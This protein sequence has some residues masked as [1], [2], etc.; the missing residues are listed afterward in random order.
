MRKHLIILLVI[1]SCLHGFTQD[2]LTIQVG[3]CQTIELNAHKDATCPDGYH[4]D[5]DRDTLKITGTLGANC[6]GTHLALI[7]KINDTIFIST[8]DTGQLCLCT[9]Y[10]CF[11]LKLPASVNDT[12]VSIHG[13]IYNTNV[14][15]DAFTEMQN[16]IDIMPNPATDNISISATTD[17]VQISQIALYSVSGAFVKSF[18]A[19][20]VKET[21]IS[22]SELKNGVYIVRVF[23][24][25]GAIINK[26]LIKN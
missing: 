6:C 8:A 7:S 10:F 20:N 26:L 25:S 22:I 1:C 9:C 12:L 3:S 2:T 18:N 16:W 14:G 24:N 15:I 19:R 17:N 11:E 23:F 21:N 4:F 13:T 5:Y